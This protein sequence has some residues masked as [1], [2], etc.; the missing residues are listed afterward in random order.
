M[1][2]RHRTEK[3]IAQETSPS[4]FGPVR[5]TGAPLPAYLEPYIFPRY[6]TDE[7]REQSL[8]ELA[9]EIAKTIVSQM[10]EGS[11]QKVFDDVLEEIGADEFSEVRRRFFQGL[12]GDIQ[13]EIIW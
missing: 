2:T 3:R 6:I 11:W 10:G 5:D 9:P 12:P 13:R 8:L 1:Y 4:Y 7:V